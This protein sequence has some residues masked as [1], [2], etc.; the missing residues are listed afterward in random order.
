MLIQNGVILT[1]GQRKKCDIR[2]SE[3]KIVQVEE[4]LE[5]LPEEEVVCAE[6]KFVAP[7]FLDIHT[8]GGMNVD[9][10]G[11]SLEDFQT[12]GDFFASR[13][14]TGWQ[15]SILTDTPEQTISCIKQAVLYS[16]EPQNGARL[17]GI[18]LEGPFLSQEY[19]GSMPT[20]LIREKLDL[21]L[22]RRY[23][24]EA[25]GL[26]RYITVSPELEGVVEGIPAMKELGITVAIGHSGADYDTAVKAIE[27]GAQ[28]ATHTMNAMLLLHQHRPAITGAVLESDI[29][30]EMICDGIHLHPGTVRLILKCKGNE[31]V[32]AVTDSIMAAGLPDGRYRLGVNDVTVLNGDAK[33]TGTDIRA[34]STL[35]TDR[36]LRNLVAFTGLP[37]ERAIMLLTQNPAD[38]LNL[39]RK[40]RVE[41]GCDAD[42][43]I[44][45]ADLYVD[46]VYVAGNRCR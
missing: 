13:G 20:H 23:Q 39:C 32:V 17:L 35:T 18:H 30:C 14:T 38:L 25:E 34:G 15:C 43:V 29:Y 10:N 45:D 24:I 36:A 11:A 16:K 7:G 31:K 2:I 28:A 6:G 40:G 5:A 1:G 12:I 33:V 26:I 37:V 46:Q 42:L 22:L 19:R 27:M 4:S 21:D 3:G 9:V 44:L 41:V 8:H